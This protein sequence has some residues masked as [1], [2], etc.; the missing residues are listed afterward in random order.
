MLG[1]STYV[2][3]GASERLMAELAA[4][5]GAEPPRAADVGIFFGRSGREVPDPYF[6][7]AGPRRTG[8]VRCGQCMLGCRYGAKNT[9]VKNYLW[10]AEAG[11]ALV[12]PGRRVIAIRP[13]RR[14]DGADGYVVTSER[15]G[16]WRQRDRRELVARGV[17]ICAGALGI[18]ELLRRCKDVGL[19]PRL[20]DRLG[21]LVRTNSEA[22][23]AVTARRGD[24]RSD[25][26][27]T[28]SI[29]PDENTHVTNN[30]YGTAGDAVA[31]GFGP[32]TGGARS[33]RRAVQHVATVLR[34]PAE[35]LGTG[36][37][38]GWSARTVIFTVMQSTESSLRL[39]PRR[40]GGRLRS[41]TNGP[42]G[43]ASYLP[44]ANRV[45]ELAAGCI[46]GLAQSSVSDSPTGRPTTAHLLGGAVIGPDP[47]LGVI[48][49]SHRI[50]GY[51]NLLVCDGAAVPANPGVNP[52]L[53]ISALAERAM[54][55]IPA[56][57]ADSRQASGSR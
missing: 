38:R 27:I 21:E 53:T 29:F 31:L 40:R 49:S 15:V 23:T 9:L 55:A 54:A 57:A 10:L 7:G 51:S 48:D 20:S 4:E 42:R 12:F 28:A 47:S 39:R 11:G 35:W 13:R 8:C 17:V 26:A 33:S 37:Y 36:R 50:F 5:L 56:A 41:E 32:L 14:P 6:S 3:D 43:F 46:D 30:T 16:A 34:R 25:V 52:S 22:I 24:Y 45:A 18:N 2:G 1:V 44:I 19:L